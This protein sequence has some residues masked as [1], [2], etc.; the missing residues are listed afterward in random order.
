MSLYAFFRLAWRPA[1]VFWALALAG[2]GFLIGTLSSAFWIGSKGLHGLIPI[3]G[4]HLHRL[5][6]SSLLFPA[7][8]GLLAGQIVHE[9][10]HCSFSWTLPALRRKLFLSVLC[11][12]LGVALLSAWWYTDPLSNLFHLSNLFQR[13][14]MPYYQS[15]FIRQER[16]KALTSP[17]Y[18]EILSYYETHGSLVA[19]LPLFALGLLWYCMGTALRV[20]FKISGENRFSLLTLVLLLLTLGYVDE[21][22]NF[23]RIRPLPSLA[24]SA[25][26]AWIYLRQG[27]S[28]DTARLEPFVPVYPLLDNFRQ[29]VAGRYR[30]EK[31]S[32]GKP[33]ETMWRGSLTG[34]GGGIIEWMSAAAYENGGMPLTRWL[35]ST[36]GTGIAV[37]LAVV[38]LG[39][40]TNGLQNVFRFKFVLWLMS[41]LV[42][43]QA[44]FSNLFL[45][46]GR[47]YPLSR[48][49]LA[50][51]TYR[52]SLLHSVILFGVVGIACS[53]LGGALPALAG[54]RWRVEV[55]SDVFRTLMPTL[56]FVPLAYWI[57]MFYGRPSYGVSL[58][59]WT[60]LSVSVGII[61][62]GWKN[63][64]PGLIPVSGI[65][66]FAGL[67]LLA[68]G[69]YRYG[70]EAYF[71]RDDLT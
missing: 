67:L 60:I 56:V 69:L 48:S 42:W 19:G 13:K 41:L 55:I 7:F 5:S 33:R 38:G 14:Y 6:L 3:L 43:N 10:Q 24:L 25:L 36:C 34:A 65:A 49:Q 27:F 39:Y 21:I 18:G 61:A 12:G 31:L 66:L 17:P 54:R 28:V 57:R 53:L 70:L 4:W 45:Q 52:M 22:T 8:A 40:L 35:M 20:P 64:L 50:A 46:K 44:L 16:Q 68:Q 15:V 29:T 63:L 58:V 71:R 47:L 62:V 9:I 11:T 37:T 51:I 30:K 59:G 2:V 1:V 32:F 23:F 26:G